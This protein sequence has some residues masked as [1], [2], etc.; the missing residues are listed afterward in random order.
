MV[1]PMIPAR[2]GIPIPELEYGQTSYIRV[3]MENSKGSWPGNTV[4]NCPRTE[5]C[6]PPTLFPMDPYGATSRWID[7]SSSGPR[8]VKFK[9]ESEDWIVVEPN[10]GRIKRDGS[11][12]MRLRVSVDWKKAPSSGGEG[13]I[14]LYGSDSSNVTIHLPIG[15]YEHDPKFKGYVQGD[16]YVAIEAAHSS[17]STSKHA[18]AFHDIVG[19]GR[20]LSG[21]EMFP[22]T[23]Q[24]FTVGEGPSLEY[25]FWVHQAGEAE[26]NLQ[27]GPTLN[28][29][30]SK[31][32][33]AFGVQVDDQ[34]PKVINPIPTE[35][36]GLYRESPERTPVAIGAVP[37]DW[38]DI[39]KDEIRDVRLPLNFTESGEHTLTI[40]G[41]TTGIILERVLVDFGGIRDRGYSYL[42]PPESMYVD[43][44]G[45]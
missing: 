35:Q 2:Q 28:F 31:K 12:D 25:T 5:H 9:V 24:N 22:R 4:Y 14:R 26:L 43:S 32:T 15:Q 11:T 6:G 39:V 13:L 19:Y 33:L 41:M 17:K 36:L 37:R 20:T 38:I 44:T 27:I 30:G 23:T 8:D 40:W 29:L 42:G 3:T 34:A 45:K 7:V 16:G 21:L 10:E 18:Y 1:N